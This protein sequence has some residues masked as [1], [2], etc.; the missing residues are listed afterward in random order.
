MSTPYKIPPARFDRRI[1]TV[2]DHNQAALTIA[3]TPILSLSALDGCWTGVGHQIM[4]WCH[5]VRWRAARAAMELGVASSIE[6][7]FILDRWLRDGRSL[8]PALEY[9]TPLNLTQESYVVLLPGPLVLRNLRQQKAVYLG[10][11][12]EASSP[13]KLVAY[14]SEGSV[15]SMAPHHAS[16]LSVSLLFPGWRPLTPTASLGKPFPVPHEGVDESE[17]V[18]VFENLYFPAPH[19]YITLGS[20]FPPSR[21]ILAIILTFTH[22]APF[23]SS[24][25]TRGLNFTLYCTYR[26]IAEWRLCICE[27]TGGAL[28]AGPTLDTGLLRPA[29]PWV[30]SRRHCS[31]L[32]TY[33]RAELRCRACRKRWEILPSLMG[34]TF[35]VSLLPLPKDYRPL[36]RGER[37]PATAVEATRCRV[38]VAVDDDTDRL[39]G[40]I[41]IVVVTVTVELD[42]VGSGNSG[43]DTG[44]GT[45]CHLRLIEPGARSRRDYCRRGRGLCRDH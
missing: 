36:A 19:A 40:R 16:S 18:V 14:V 1:A 11:V 9:P 6:R 27:L 32:W 35:I 7:R 43:T 42:A 39:C 41:V 45:G 24:V 21:T 2:F 30:S 3:E 25:H 4:V 29:G 34:A 10:P 23:T 15:L 20:P 28:L 22:W 5:Q 12:P 8:P 26:Q 37:P 44:T 13:T 38:G 17:G 31:P 33:M